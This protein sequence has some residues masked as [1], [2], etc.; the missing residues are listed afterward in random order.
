MFTKHDYENYKAMYE[1]NGA[2]TLD[3]G[4]T[5]YIIFG[6][7]DCVVYRRFGRHSWK[8]KFVPGWRLKSYTQANIL[9][10]NQSWVDEG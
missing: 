6:V 9:L 2:F 5:K 8:S 1:T 3:V 7:R 4:K 10:R